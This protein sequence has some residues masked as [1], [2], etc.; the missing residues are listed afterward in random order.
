MFPVFAVGER[1]VRM[2]RR[3]CAVEK[4]PDNI[5]KENFTLIIVIIILLITTNY[6]AKK[7]CSC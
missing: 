7:S 5:I 2:I 1:K 3:S 6:L 4:E